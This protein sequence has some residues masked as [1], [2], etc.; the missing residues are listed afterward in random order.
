MEILGID[1]TSAPSRRKPIT[2]TF[3]V[4][5]GD[6]LTVTGHDRLA[7]LAAFEALLARPGPW[8]AGFDFPFSFARGFLQA[9]GWPLDW[10]SLAAHLAALEKSAYLSAIA[11]FR[12]RQPVGEKHLPRALDR[13]TG[14]AAPNNIVNPP[15]G[16]MLFEAVPRL[17]GGGP[18]AAGPCSRRSRP[19]GGRGL[20]RHRGEAADRYHRL[21]GRPGP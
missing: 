17:R 16:R 19:P 18:H 15:V 4:L 5:D 10:P 8:V 12:D 9:M 7:S 13:L 20:P 1:F 3:A 11:A 14:G 6:R 21:Q 2:C